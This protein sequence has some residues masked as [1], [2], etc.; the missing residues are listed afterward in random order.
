[1]KRGHKEI[2]KAILKV[3]YDG[4]LYSYGALER[5]VNTNWITIREHCDDLLIFELA[6]QEDNKIKITNKGRE[7]LK[8]INWLDKKK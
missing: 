8:K 6:M 5:S 4:K 3:L 7:F 2:R 1:M